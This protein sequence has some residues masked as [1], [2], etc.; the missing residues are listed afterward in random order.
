ME[1]YGDQIAQISTALADPTRRD[2]MQHV[3]GADTPLSALQVAQHF[4]LHVNAARM[5][6]DK[7]VKGGLLR[8]I[9]R[10]DSRGGRPAH[11]YFEND[12]E[13][14]ILFPSR[15]YKTLAEILL[16]GTQGGH[17]EITTALQEEASRRGREEALRG[18]SPLA[19][20]P[21]KASI[22]EVVEAWLADAGRRGLKARLNRDNA[23]AMSMTFLSCPF[24]K[25]S[26]NYPDTVC[27]IHRCLEEGIL[28]L[29]GHWKVSSGSVDNPCVFLLKKKAERT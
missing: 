1:S 16:G 4:G 23:K 10:R 19:F 25:F 8:V 2:I 17:Q 28:S 7:L 26:E 24:G 3:L 14:E 29:C 22:R 18:S 9:R 11:L 5:H 21:A 20:L 13:R 27:E 15:C 6:L 12:E